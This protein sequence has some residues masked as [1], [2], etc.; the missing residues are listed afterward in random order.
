MYLSMDYIRLSQIS[1]LIGLSDLNVGRDGLFGRFTI[2]ISD[3]VQYQ[4]RSF[5][6]RA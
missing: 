6:G 2:S 1:L 3:L 5:L 4:V